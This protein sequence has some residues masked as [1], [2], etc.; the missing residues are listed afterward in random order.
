MKIDSRTRVKNISK[1]IR[2]KEGGLAPAAWF[3]VHIEEDIV[4]RWACP[5]LSDS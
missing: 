1:K 3:R 5:G 2:G 4:G